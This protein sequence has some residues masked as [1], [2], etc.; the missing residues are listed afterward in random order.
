MP[1]PRVMERPRKVIFKLDEEDYERLK[2][3]A[4]KKGVSV[5]ELLRHIIKQAVEG[6]MPASVPEAKGDNNLAMTIGV[7][8]SLRAEEL[9]Q[10]IDWRIY[11]EIS[12]A[13][14]RA[15]LNGII[16][17]KGALQQAHDAQARPSDELKARLRELREE[18]R[19]LSR[20]VRSQSVLKPLGEELVALSNKLGVPLFEGW[21]KRRA[22]A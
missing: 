9:L 22:C 1:R 8:R 16:E 3:I 13:K 20:E 4:R 11:D 10:L 2:E 15:I 14:A 5:S 21:R 6:N 18:Y 17:L 7:T 19:E 12:K